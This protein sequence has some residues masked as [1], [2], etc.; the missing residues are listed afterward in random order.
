[1]FYVRY[2]HLRHLT[3]TVLSFKI[4]AGTKFLGLNVVVYIL[5]MFKRLNVNNHNT[6]HCHQPL[7]MEYFIIFF[8]RLTFSKKYHNLNNFIQFQ[9]A[10][11]ASY[12]IVTCCLPCVLWTFMSFSPN[13]LTTPCKKL[14]YI[15]TNFSLV[16]FMK[17]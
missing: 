16:A 17:S 5:Y 8:H 7:S 11:I 1:M 4:D 14:K 3:K 15:V 2:N 6:H 12:L 13:K 10:I 9:P